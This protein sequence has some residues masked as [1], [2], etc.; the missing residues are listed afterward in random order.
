M[1]FAFDLS[2][3]LFFRNQVKPFSL[4]KAFNMAFEGADFEVIIPF[5]I[6]SCFLGYYHYFDNED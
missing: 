3:C 2:Y 1:K 6:H 5:D 4:E